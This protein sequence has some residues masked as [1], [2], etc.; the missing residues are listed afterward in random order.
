MGPRQDYLATAPISVTPPAGWT[1]QVSHND[2]GD[3]YSI[4]FVAASPTGDVQAGQSLD[5]SFTSADPPASVGGDSVYYPNVPVGTSSVY[6]GVPFSDAGHQFIVTS[7]PTLASIAITPGNPNVPLGETDQFTAVGTFAD[8]STENLTDQV[9]WAS[10]ATSMATISN[11]AGSQGLATTVA[12]GPTTISATLDGITGST[13]L[14]VIRP[15]SN[16][17]HSRRTISSM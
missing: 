15:R 17:S 10:T 8:N 12:Q 11:T 13:V 3:G 1:D 9:A 2:S 6:P 7:A 5:F 14:T 4:Q 16:R